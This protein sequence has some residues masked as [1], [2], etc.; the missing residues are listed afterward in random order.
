[1]N[2]SIV[3]APAHVP[4]A[5]PSVVRLAALLESSPPDTLYTARAF[6][7]THSLSNAVFT[8]Y[9]A[10]PLLTP[11]RVLSKGQSTLWGC[12][13]AVVRKR[14]EDATLHADAKP[15]VAPTIGLT[16]ESSSH[17]TFTNA[18]ASTHP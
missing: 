9:S 1:M 6:C 11:F 13:Q 4:E 8:R 3:T 7:V 17:H 2:L 12:R 5:P 16:N 10:H 15:S 18:V 14:A